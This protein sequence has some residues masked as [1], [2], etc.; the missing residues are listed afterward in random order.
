MRDPVERSRWHVLWLLARGLTAKVIAGI[1]GYSAYWIGQIARRYNAYGPDGVKDLRQQ[2]RPGRQ[3]LTAAEHEV[4]EVEQTLFG[5]SYT[6]EGELVAPDGRAPRVRV[7]W[8][9]EAGAEMPRLVTAYPAKG[10]RG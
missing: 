3:L 5:T 1:T 8:F 10:A 7:V 4:A 6:V 9:I 2:P